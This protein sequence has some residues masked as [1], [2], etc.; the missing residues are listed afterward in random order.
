MH[1][2]GQFASDRLKFLQNRN[3]LVEAALSGANTNS[4]SSEMQL[5]LY[6]LI[7][8]EADVD[9]ETAL[10]TYKDSYWRRREHQIITLLMRLRLI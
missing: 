9:R 10:S 4:F 5:T 7:K 2:S 3:S 6:L 8:N 1:D